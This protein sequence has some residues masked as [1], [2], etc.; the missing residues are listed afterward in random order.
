METLVFA[1]MLVA[2]FIYKN[3]RYIQAY[4]KAFHDILVKRKVLEPL[5]D[6]PRPIFKS[7]AVY[8]RITSK[9]F[10]RNVFFCHLLN[11]ADTL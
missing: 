6:R 11:L 9:I 5:Y 10:A 7:W 3:I 4:Q 1:K 8:V 2:V